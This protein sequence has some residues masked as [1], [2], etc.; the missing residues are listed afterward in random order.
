M[1]KMR[2]HM[3]YIDKT[4]CLQKGIIAFPSIY[5]MGAAATGKSVL[6]EKFLNNNLQVKSLTVDMMKADKEVVLEQIENVV[7]YM[8]A[9]AFIL[10]LE[11]LP[12]QSDINPKIVEFIMNMPENGR[13]ILVGRNNLPEDMLPL[14]WGRR[15]EIISQER[16][17]FTLE[18]VRRLGAFWNSPLNAEEVWKYTGGWA[19]CV[20]LMMRMS[21]NAALGRDRKSLETLSE[22]LRNSYEINTY[23]EKYIRGMLS[24]EEQRILNLAI[25]CPWVNLTLSLPSFVKNWDL[26]VRQL[27][28]QCSASSSG[29][30]LPLRCVLPI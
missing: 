8:K 25:C 30:E 12:A 24:G 26:W 16:F 29:A 27:S 6:I 9:G 11:N 14:L 10:V 7:E 4:E 23:I 18:D 15:L 22:E 1:S 5:I 19:G 28:L 2:N 3:H 13:V 21:A 17:S 20:D